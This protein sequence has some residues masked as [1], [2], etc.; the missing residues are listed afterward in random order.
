MIGHEDQRRVEGGGPLDGVMAGR[1]WDGR[2]SQTLGQAHGDG[3]LGT[4]A[5]WWTGHDVGERGDH[6]AGVTGDGGGAQVGPGGVGGPARTSAHRMR[7]ETWTNGHSP[8]SGAVQ[9]PSTPV[10]HRSPATSSKVSRDA[11]SVAG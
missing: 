4:A 7:S 3:E 10:P 1:L 6:P 8:N 9:S 11:N 2:A 5:S